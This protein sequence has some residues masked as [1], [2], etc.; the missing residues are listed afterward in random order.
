[1]NFLYP[2]TLMVTFFHELSHALAAL[3]SGGHVLSLQIN[4]DGSGLCTTS[5]GNQLIIIAAGYLG[6]ILIGNLLLYVGVRWHKLAPAVLLVIATA[7]L[8]SALMWYGGSFS[9]LVNVVFGMLLILISLKVPKIGS[10]FLILLGIYSVL[11]ILHDYNVGPTSDLAAF[12]QI[13]LLPAVIWMY[14][15]LGIAVL[16]TGAN[17]YLM[18]KK[19]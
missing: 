11:Y 12:S 4:A 19:K 13:A 15:W 2:F 6:S 5:G 18:L 1:M 7:L 10:I 17:I 14:L 8:I 16:I 9:F 3:V